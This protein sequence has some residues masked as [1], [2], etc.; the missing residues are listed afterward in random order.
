MGR[1]KIDE[2]KSHFTGAI[3]SVT[4]AGPNTWTFQY[5]AFSWTIKADGADQPTPFGETAMKVVNPST[6]QFINKT[7]GKLSGDET[8]TLSADGQSITRTF[9]GQKENGERF[10]GYETVKRIAGTS[11]FAGTW[12][13]TDVKMTFTEV[14]IEPNGADGITLRLPRRR[15]PLFAQVRWQGLSGGKAPE[16]RPA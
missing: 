16:S 5:G 3:D 9:G 11:G 12:E 8:W 6:W 7:N 13:S 14:D 1:W 10:S 4:A 2:A 15:D